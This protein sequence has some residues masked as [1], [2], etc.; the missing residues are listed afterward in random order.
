MSLRTRLAR[1]EKSQ[2]HCPLCG[3]SA[4]IIR[5]WREDPIGSPRRPRGDHTPPPPCPVCGRTPGILELIEQVVSTRE[6]AQ[7]A[8][9]AMKQEEPL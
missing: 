1:L 4:P 2:G 5:L 8:M 6:E 7:A 3:D 9:Q